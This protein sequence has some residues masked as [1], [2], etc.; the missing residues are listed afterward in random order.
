MMAGEFKGCMERWGDGIGYNAGGHR[1]RCAE[2]KTVAPYTT[3]VTTGTI[4][5]ALLP[6]MVFNI[7]R[8]PNACFDTLAPMAMTAEKKT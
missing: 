8:M 1:N 3:C 5:Y 6:S 2:L 7:A 4:A